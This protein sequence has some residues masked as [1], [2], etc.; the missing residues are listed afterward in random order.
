[1]A[2]FDHNVN[3]KYFV[4]QSLAAFSP[5]HDK[6]VLEGYTM[7]PDAMPMAL[8]LFRKNLAELMNQTEN[9]ADFSAML[10]DA[11]HGRLLFFGRLGSIPMYL[12]DAE[13]I[14]RIKIGIRTLVEMFFKAGAKTVYAP[15]LGYEKI[16][17]SFDGELFSKTRFRA[18]D[19]LTL[20]GH[21]PLGTCVM[22]TNASNSVV[23]SKGKVWGV[24][25][26]YITDASVIPGPIGVNPQV[27]IMANALRIARAVGEDLKANS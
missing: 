9:F 15:A 26:L 4:P 11:S 8:A 20:S 22:G 10:I 21:H 17:G 24:E 2:G 18:R 23:S 25:N 6:F 7:V 5:N 12:F 19:F 16:E 13:G 14:D 27:T 3:Q 1:M